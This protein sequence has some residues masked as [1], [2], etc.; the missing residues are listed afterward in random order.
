MGQPRR[1]A[2][3]SA[4]V[5]GARRPREPLGRGIDPPNG[6]NPGIV[7]RSK[8]KSQPFQQVRKTL[9]VLFMFFYPWLNI[10]EAVFH[11][12]SRRKYMSSI[13]GS[14]SLYSTATV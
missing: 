11:E 1:E 10:A 4:P 7:R 14:V 6:Q 8:P 2:H 9:G 5:L 3:R 13:V 12:L